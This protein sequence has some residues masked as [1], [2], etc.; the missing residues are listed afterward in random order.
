[1][2][3]D[4]HYVLNN[5]VFCSLAFCSC[6]FQ[7][8][9]VLV[10]SSCQCQFLVVVNT[11]LQQLLVLIFGSC[12]YQ[13]LVVTSVGFQY[14]LLVAVSTSF[15][16]CQQQQ[17][18]PAYSS[19]KPQQLEVVSISFKKLLLI[20]LTVVSTNFQFQWCTS[21]QQLLLINFYQ[22]LAPFSVVF[23]TSFYQLL[24][25]VFVSCQYIVFVVSNLYLNYVNILLLL[26]LSLETFYNSWNLLSFAEFN[27]ILYQST[28]D[29]RSYS[30]FSIKNTFT[31]T[32]VIAF[33]QFE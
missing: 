2:I 1:M 4:F 6:N 32:E 11:I 10:V 15:S 3:D 7:Q 31:C 8:L 12:Q 28:T 30:I 24:V 25:L 18:V 22:L 26:V 33:A 20:I 14:Q 23:I 9:L 19:C 21:F 17:L 13:L 16:I 27:T 29:L 5:L